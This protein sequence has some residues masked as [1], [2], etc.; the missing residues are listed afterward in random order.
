MTKS[1]H[2]TIAFQGVPGAYSDLAA[3]KYFGRNCRTRPEKSFA[4]IFASVK[5]GQARYGI[6]P[7][8]N[9]ITGSIHQN[10]DLLAKENLKIVGEVFLKIS[11]HLMAKKAP[12]KTAAEQLNTI[13]KAYSH[14][15]ALMQCEQFFAQHPWIKAA[16]AADTA[17]S[18][19]MVSRQKRTTIAAIASLQAAKLYHLRVL[20]KNIETN[21]HN[22]TRFF[23]ITQ[24][25]SVT[26]P[27][28]ASILLALK[29]IP[30]S[31]YQALK[32]LAQA[33]INLTKIESRPIIGH[34]WE[35]LFYIDV[36][37]PPNLAQ[38]ERALKK[39]S[40]FCNYVKIIGS[41]HKANHV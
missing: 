18:A 5:S 26:K 23:I 20:A 38:Y 33:K 2:P 8:E 29:H 15:Q 37:I 7:I 17:G 1:T 27:T 40:R 10:Y 16:A 32:P 13:T 39:M 14:P 3:H 11:H 19:L 25:S 28:K 22:Y 6:I 12:G 21:K 30:G 41:Y 31:L 4:A 9:S 34:P 36:E 24:T 35:Y